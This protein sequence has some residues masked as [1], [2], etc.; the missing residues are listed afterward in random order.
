MQLRSRS[1][2]SPSSGTPTAT[3]PTQPGGRKGT[4]VHP[5]GDDLDILNI[6][7][8]RWFLSRS[9]LLASTISAQKTEDG[10]FSSVELTPQ[11]HSHLVKCAYTLVPHPVSKVKK[12][13]LVFILELLNKED[14][15]AFF[16]LLKGGRKANNAQRENRRNRGP[17][18]KRRR[19]AKAAK[20][21]K[22]T[23]REKQCVTCGCKFKSLK[24][25][26][27]HKCPKSKVVSAS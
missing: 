21:A 5:K 24:T 23:P 3:P 17:A 4:K 2:S 13:M 22:L 15:M 27:K 7:R 6:F 14:N 8:R 26:R 19:A 25:S 10:I 11:Y 16:D 12:V 18:R 9:H 1:L 20:A